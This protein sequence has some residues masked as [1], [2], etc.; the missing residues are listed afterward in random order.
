[1]S[2]L[3]PDLHESPE[4]LAGA[5]RGG[6]SCGLGGFF[7]ALNSELFGFALDSMSLSLSSGRERSQQ[8]IRS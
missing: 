3:R 2:G 6:L 7:A 5:S 4:G 8:G 1:M